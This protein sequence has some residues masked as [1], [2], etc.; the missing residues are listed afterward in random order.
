MNPL[1]KGNVPHLQEEFIYLEYFP[2]G[3][4]R[5]EYALKLFISR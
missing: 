1:F 2:W 4:K 5:Q 3:E